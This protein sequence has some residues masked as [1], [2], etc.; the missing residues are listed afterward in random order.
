MKTLKSRRGQSLIEYL[1]L[2]AIMGVA[3]LGVIRVLSAT[4]NAKFAQVTKALN[5]DTSRVQT[6]Q[7]TTDLYQ[8]RDL[9]DFFE[10]A[11]H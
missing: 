1:L 8:K 2:V 7:V 4:V 9:G 3:S 11:G 6:E 5:G 10:N